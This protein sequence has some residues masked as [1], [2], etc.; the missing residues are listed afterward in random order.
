MTQKTMNCQD[1]SK[2]FLY[3]CRTVKFKKTISGILQQSRSP[4]LVPSHTS[5]KVCHRARSQLCTL[6][7]AAECDSD[8]GKM[9]HSFG[10]QIC[11]LLCFSSTKPESKGPIWEDVNYCMSGAKRC[12]LLQFC[13]VCVTSHPIL[14]SG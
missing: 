8:T 6:H 10:W 4:W 14:S 1:T 12:S 3:V 13:W 9:G 7:I 11:L 2:S 5:P